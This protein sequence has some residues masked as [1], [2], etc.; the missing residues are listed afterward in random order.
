[1][2]QSKKIGKQGDSQ[3]K[4]GVQGKC[5]PSYTAWGGEGGG[6]RRSR[7]EKNCCFEEE[8]AYRTMKNSTSSYKQVI[9]I[10]GAE[11]MGWDGDGKFY[12]GLAKSD[13][14]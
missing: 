4:Q 6:V 12:D 8:K 14:S 7:S 10:V 9:S 2:Q 1:M 11:W 5:M 13:Q 3:L